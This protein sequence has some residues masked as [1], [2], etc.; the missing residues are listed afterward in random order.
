MIAAAQPDVA[1]Q[2]TAVAW[3]L[4][5]AV[6]IALA[7]F[8]ASKVAARVARRVAQC[9]WDCQH[10]AWLDS[11]EPA[12]TAGNCWA[13]LTVIGGENVSTDGH[14]YGLCPGCGTA[15]PSCTIIDPHL[16]F[17]PWVIDEHP[18]YIDPDHGLHSGACW[19]RKLDTDDFGLCVCGEV[20]A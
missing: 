11:I 6:V 4:I 10:Q 20:A 13:G 15:N 14:L 16:P 2:F 12:P 8:V 7:A 9:E 18:P 3:T 19:T 1:G 17:G 5:A